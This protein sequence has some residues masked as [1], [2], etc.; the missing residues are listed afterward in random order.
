MLLIVRN[1]KEMEMILLTALGVGG[2]TVVGAILGFIFRGACERYSGF[3]MSFAAGVMLMAAIS[4]LIVPAYAENPIELIPWAIMGV[5]LGAVTLYLIERFIPLSNSDG[6]VGALLFA[7][8]IAIHNLPEGIA[9]GV[10]FGGEGGAVGV[11]LG[12]ALHN[13]PEGMIVITPMLAAGV[14][15]GR[16]FLYAIA[17][18]VAEVIGTFIGYFA[19]SISA[20]ILPFV[21]SFAGG[22]MLTVIAGDMIPESHSVGSRRATFSLI[23]GFVIMMLVDALS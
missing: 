4:G 16:T 2:A 7:I 18:G 3:I 9:A 14:S 20:A 1:N 17:G 8:A 21:L 13:L 11:V 23:L 5:L 19:V 12:I 22:T 10:A 6:E 15:P